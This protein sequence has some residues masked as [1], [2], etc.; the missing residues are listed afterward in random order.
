MLKNGIIVA[1]AEGNEQD[2]A[3]Y[4]SDTAVKVFQDYLA[5]F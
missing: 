2:F 3:T 1:S 4:T 5:Y